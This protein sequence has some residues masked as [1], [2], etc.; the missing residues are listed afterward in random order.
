[1]AL[2]IEIEKPSGV[3]TAEKGRGE[4]GEVIYSDTR[5]YMQLHQFEDAP[6]VS[7]IIT[8]LEGASLPGVLYQDFLNPRSVGLLTY[9]VD[10]AW[11]VEGFRD[12]VA[13]DP[14]RQM[15]HRSDLTMGGRTYA[16]GYERNLGDVLLKRPI[17][18]ACN[19]EWPW[20]IWYPL[21][22]SGEFSLLSA[23]EQRTMLMEHGGI[24]R[25]YGKADLAHDIRLSCHGLDRHDNDFVVALVGKELTPLSKVVER[26]RSTQQT[27]GYI[28]R[29]G[30]F[31]VG[32][33]VWLNPVFPSVDGE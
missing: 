16:I 2:Q 21:S 32:R 5:L 18:H 26:M 19:P 22:R 4:D 29:M 6:P 9:S 15:K 30:P 3:N 28:Q 8:A 7:E 25:A 31:F 1:M 12:V 20:A 24:G 10:P 27:A 33:A 13:S 17:R 11:F 23:D 14:F